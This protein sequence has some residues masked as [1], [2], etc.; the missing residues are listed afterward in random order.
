MLFSEKDLALGLLQTAVAQ[1]ISQPSPCLPAEQ[2]L[3]Q[4]QELQKPPQETQQATYRWA[5]GPLPVLLFPEPH[6]GHQHPPSLA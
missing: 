4:L 5:Q 2:L 1:L 3:N 6:P